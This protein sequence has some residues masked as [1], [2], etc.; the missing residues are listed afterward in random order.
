MADCDMAL[1]AHDDADLARRIEA[2][3]HEALDRLDYGV[4]RLDPAGRVAFYSATE[5]RQSG[6]RG[7]GPVGHDFFTQIAPCMNT[8]EFR[9]R[10]E[11]ARAAG[12]LDI[13]FGHVGDFAD[14]ARALVVRVLSAA[15]GGVWILHR[16]E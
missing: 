9:G 11:R 13:E 8:P 6:F 10:I 2:L 5:R 16:R 4:I 7:E 12:R 14:R 1:P 15:D 3:P